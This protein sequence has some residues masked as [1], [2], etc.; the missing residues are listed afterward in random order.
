MAVQVPGVVPDPGWIRGRFGGAA[1]KPGQLLGKRVRDIKCSLCTNR[2]T[3]RYATAEQWAI[4][5]RQGFCAVTGAGR[6]RSIGGAV[7]EI[8][9]NGLGVMRDFPQ[10]LSSFGG[11][12]HDSLPYRFW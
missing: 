9:Q 6:G 8:P 1:T 2:H 5:D 10:G 3:I 4:I 7:W 12:P 11:S